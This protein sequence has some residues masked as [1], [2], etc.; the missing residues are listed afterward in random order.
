M[1]RV[2][3][4]ERKAGKNLYTHYSDMSIILLNREALSEPRDNLHAVH[5]NTVH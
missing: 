1:V 3:E 5:I 2:D 4:T